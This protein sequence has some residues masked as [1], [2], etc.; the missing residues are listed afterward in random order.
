LPHLASL[1]FDPHRAVAAV[2]AEALLLGFFPARLFQATVKT[3]I[4]S[5]E[6]L[7]Q[8]NDLTG[9]PGKMFNHVKDEAVSNW[10]DVLMLAATR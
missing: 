1:T 6:A 4:F 10:A 3:E 7:G 5:S 8:Q 2:L 9:V